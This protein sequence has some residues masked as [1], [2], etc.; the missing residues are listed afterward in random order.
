MLSYKSLWFR[1]Y[2]GILLAALVAV[3]SGTVQAQTA[4]LRLLVASHETGKPL[5]NVEVSLLKTTISGTTDADGWVVLEN[6]D[7]GLQ[8][9]SVHRLGF[10]RE[11]IPVT[12]EADATLEADLALVTAPIPLG[13]IEITAEKVDQTLEQ[14]GFYERQEKGLGEF[15]TRE[16]L[17][18]HGKNTMIEA[19]RGI[20]GVRF[21]QMN[22]VLVAVSTRAV[23]A[24]GG[25]FSARPC[26]F[27]I[28]VDGTKLGN[29]AE[30]L[31]EVVAL[32]NVAGIEV[33]K[34]ASGL[35][36]AFNQF[37]ACGAIVVWTLGGTAQ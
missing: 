15:I 8:M 1:M 23:T 13:E 25:A 3:S 20:H 22:G 5:A 24:E 21:Q 2:L 6:I 27:S 7:P 12:F 17:D 35:P 32:N 4:S 19:L 29:G 28:Y 36:P 34:G 31:D 30:V 9:L 10:Q 16:E 33:Y 18:Q 26:P 11:L 14:R 37:S